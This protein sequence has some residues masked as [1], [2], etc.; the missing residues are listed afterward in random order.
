MLIAFSPRQDVINLFHR[1]KRKLMPPSAKLEGYESEE[2]IDVIFRKTLAYHPIKEDWPDVISAATVLDF[3]GACGAHYKE[4]ILHTPD[5][6]WAVVETPAMMHR[7]SELASDRLKFFTS[8]AAAAAWLGP[9][10]LMHSSGALQYVLDPQ[11]SVSEL[12]GV[13]ATRLHWRRLVLSQGAT[14]REMQASF[15]ADNGPGVIDSVQEKCVEYGRTRI[16]EQAFLAA[17]SAH[18]RP[19]DRGEDWFRFELR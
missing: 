2:L 17:H 3:G 9:I 6:R 4:A 13:G 12:C 19:V 18:Y 7:A 8:I 11:K 16:P 10:D 5:V 14:I 1:L 15:L